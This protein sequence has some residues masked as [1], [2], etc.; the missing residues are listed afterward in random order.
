MV[1]I[2]TFYGSLVTTT[3]IGSAFLLLLLILGYGFHIREITA[4]LQRLSRRL[5]RRG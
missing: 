4:L 2:R 5:K 3:V 1:D